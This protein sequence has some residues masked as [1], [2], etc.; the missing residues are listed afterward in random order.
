MLGWVCPKTSPQSSLMPPV[1]HLSP[2]ATDC[3]AVLQSFCRLSV[4]GFVVRYSPA[5]GSL[6]GK[7]HFTISLQPVSIC[8]LGLCFCAV[9]AQAASAW[10][11]VFPSGQVMEITGTAFND[12]HLPY[13]PLVWRL[14]VS[15]AIK[16]F[17][18][19]FFLL[20]FCRCQLLLS[21]R[22]EVWRQIRWCQ[23]PLL[24]GV[25]T[26]HFLTPHCTSSNIVLFG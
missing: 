24:R 3:H 1:R 14:A 11:F 6:L 10:L 13:A 12:R 21:L 15:I 22:L 8:F 5:R 9:G 19:M 20:W 17:I 18:A 26:P 2:V 23:N 7:H 25:L 16:N 4:S